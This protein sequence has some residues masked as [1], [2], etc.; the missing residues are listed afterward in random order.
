MHL[1]NE[2]ITSTACYHY[3]VTPCQACPRQ[4]RER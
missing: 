3:L 1:Y 2:Y 4:C